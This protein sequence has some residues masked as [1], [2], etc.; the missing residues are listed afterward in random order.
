[1]KCFNIYKIFYI[2]LLKHEKTYIDKTIM[3]IKEKMGALIQVSFYM[4][5]CTMNCIVEESSGYEFE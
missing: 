5:D 3:K 4:A 2:K 1:M